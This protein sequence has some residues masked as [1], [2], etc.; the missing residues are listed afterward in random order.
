MV[1]FFEKE[2]IFQIVDLSNIAFAKFKLFSYAV[3]VELV[4]TAIFAVFLILA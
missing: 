1:Y 3:Y 2:L 4:A